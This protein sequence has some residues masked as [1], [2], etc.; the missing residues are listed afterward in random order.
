ME[1]SWNEQRKELQRLIKLISDHNG[2]DDPKWLYD[3]CQ[4]VITNYHANL[5]DALT[6]F[7]S[8]AE[9]LEHVSKINNGV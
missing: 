6:C 9:Q 1:M 8:L 2:G 3:Y 4:E 7:Q 5:E